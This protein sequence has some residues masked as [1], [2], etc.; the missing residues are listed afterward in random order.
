MRTHRLRRIQPWGGRLEDD[1]EL[2]LPLLRDAE[3]PNPAATTP[4][5]LS[6]RV[7]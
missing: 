6:V 4:V 1:P 5:P 2:A 7:N 3:P